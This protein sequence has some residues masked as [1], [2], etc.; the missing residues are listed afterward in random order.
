MSLG[1]LYFGSYLRAQRQEEIG[2]VCNWCI[3]VCVVDRD[4]W[5]K[6]RLMI[7]D[8]DNFASKKRRNTVYELKTVGNLVLLTIA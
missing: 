4:S 8:N 6:E 5:K 1:L 7:N 3:I 2:T